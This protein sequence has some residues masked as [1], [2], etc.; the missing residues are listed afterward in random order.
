MWQHLYYTSGKKRYFVYIDMV[1]RLT[2][3]NYPNIINQNL[4]T[5]T[6]KKIKMRL[7]EEIK[8]KEFRDVHQK[9]HINLI[10][11]NYRLE[12]LYK[13]F[14]SSFDLTQQQYN[15]L[16]ILRGAKEQPVTVLYIRER[17]LDKM[18]DASR[19]VERLRVKKLI[20]RKPNKIDRRHVDITITK[21]GLQLLEKIDS[22]IIELQAIMQ[23]LSKDEANQLNHLLDKLR[24]ATD[25]FFQKK[26]LSEAPPNAEE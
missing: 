3:K 17:M 8:Q 10:F 25:Q 2:N 7:E 13:N 4:V 20:L 23:A 18:C 14:F 6:I 22:E 11:T 12:Y 19:I 26:K 1:Y 16:R 9:A 5:L 24:E 15:V 21:E